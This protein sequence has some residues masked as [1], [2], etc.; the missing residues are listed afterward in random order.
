MDFEK[1]QERRMH[2]VMALFYAIVILVF[3]AFTMMKNSK[4]EE[5]EKAKNAQATPTVEVTMDANAQSK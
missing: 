3:F 2:R 1:K 5:E 4:E